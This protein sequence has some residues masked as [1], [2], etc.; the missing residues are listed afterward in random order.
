MIIELT[1]IRDG[2]KFLYNTETQVEIINEG[3]GNPCSWMKDGKM[4]NQVVEDYEEI[5]NVMGWKHPR[6]KRFD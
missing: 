1:K 2:K 3:E 4:C 5:K 6:Q